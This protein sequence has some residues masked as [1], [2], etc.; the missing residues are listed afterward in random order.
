MHHSFDINLAAIYGINAAIIIHH[1][2]HWISVNRRL[3]RNFHDGRTWSYQSFDEIAANFP[4]FTKDQVRDAISLL[5]NGKTRRSKNDELCFE[6][7]LMKANYNK[8]PFDRTLWYAFIDEEKFS[9]SSYERANDQI[10]KNNCPDPKVQPPTPIPD[11]KTHTKTDIVC[12]VSPPVVGSPP[13]DNSFVEEV[14]VPRSASG[15]E[16]TTCNKQHP[17]G[18]RYEISLDSI[19][20]QAVM[21]RENFTLEEINRAWQAIVET[22]QCVRDPYAFISG[23]IKKFRQSEGYNQATRKKTQGEQCKTANLSN[24]ETMTK[25]SNKPKEECSAS[26]SSGH[27]FARFVCP[28]K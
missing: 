19:I 6:P 2:Q 11:T 17:D 22:K 4:Y 12:S 28:P 25:Q 16:S 10:E 7:V 3:K 24:S 15:K 23:T 14:S 5:C 21:K 8:T 26:V 1:F 18:K 13:L 27:L 9:N 20:T